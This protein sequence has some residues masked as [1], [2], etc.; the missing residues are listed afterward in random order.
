MIQIMQLQ[1]IELHIKRRWILCEM[2]TAVRP[3]RHTRL[4]NAS[5]ISGKTT[6]IIRK[7]NT[8]I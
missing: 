7:H 1:I 4:S 6:I 3:R 5:K 2:G 8:T